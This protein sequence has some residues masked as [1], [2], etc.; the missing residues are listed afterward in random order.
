MTAAGAATGADVPV[1]AAGPGLLPAPPSGAARLQLLGPFRL[2]D[3]TGAGVALASPRAQSLLA[4]LALNRSAPTTRR[5]LSF[6]LWPDSSESGASNNLRQLLHQVRRSWP[7]AGEVLVARNG[8]LTLAGD[9]HLAVDLDAYEVAVG[10]ALEA[11]ETAHPGPA[12]L[13]LEL[14][15]DGY[16]GPLLPAMYDEWILPERERLATR[17]E[18]LL[19]RLIALLEQSGDYRAAIERG[20]ER[21]LLDPLDERVVRVLMR[22]HALNG[23]RA[24]ALR[25]YGACAAALEEAF[26]VEPDETTRAEH[27]RVLALGETATGTATATATHP[28][29]SAA[30]G[31]R[32]PLGG[33]SAAIGS[34]IG[35]DDEWLRVGAAWERMAAGDAHVVVI[36]GVAGIG[37]SR[38]A[39]EL[40]GWATGQGIGAASTRAYQAE[41]RLSFAPIADWLRSPAVAPA[42]ARLDLGTLSEIS[43]L[44]PEL[45]VQR[46]DLPRPSARLESWQRG[47]FFGAL[48]TAFQAADQPL[49]LVLDDL[50]WCDVDTLDWLQFLLRSASASRIL[51]VSTVRSDEIDRGHPMVPFLAALREHDRVTELDLVPLGPDA[52]AALAASV[53]RRTLPPSQARRIF[54][55]TEGNPL[56]IVETVRAELVDVDRAPAGAQHVRSTTGAPLPPRIQATIAA[57]L[58]RL[59]EPARDLASLAATIGRAFTLDVVRAS[60]VDD[61]DRLVGAMDELVRHQLIREGGGGA[62]DFSHDKIREVAYAG[63]TEARRRLLHRRVADALETIHAGNL[64]AVAARIAA[65]CA[66]AGLGDRAATLYQLAAEVAQLVGANGEAIELLRRGLAILD[67]LPRSRDR[68]DRELGLQTALGSSLVA[69][70]GY[71]SDAV[72]TVYARCR[73]LCQVVGRPPAPPVLRALAISA[74]AKVRIDECHA[75]GD[76]LV[77]VAE[78]DDDPIL[79]VEAHYVIAMAQLLAGAVVPA[80]LELETAMASYDPARSSAHIGLY[81]QDPAVVCGI[82]L[83]VALWILGEPEAAE[84]RRAEAVRLAEELGHPFTLSYA[85]VWDAVLQQFRGRADLARMQAEAAIGLGHNQRM[86]FFLALATIIRGWSIAELGDPDGGIAEMR[87]GM[88]SFA[89]T[90]ALAFRTLQLALLAEQL[91]RSGAV[92]RGLTMVAEALAAAERTNERWVEAH[93]HR[94][95]GDMLRAEPAGSGPARAAYGRAIEVARYQGARAFGSRAEAQLATLEAGDQT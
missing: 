56:F 83:S 3:S 74:L 93:L 16:I 77:S 8:L 86:P 9:P 32:P 73:E 28:A 84:R 4:L 51:V 41:G 53:A 52:T 94:L 50:Q 36:G 64:D 48:A 69:T 26:G 71:G 7:G 27:A 20:S 42:L 21:L 18:R 89:A 49:L 47:A 57:R 40:Q 45:L 58:A 70:E 31:R 61:E 85:L 65:H 79:R 95:R 67:G 12:R 1:E 44:L 76:H 33:A 17:H 62:Y 39:A 66:A 5:H 91:G 24:G 82:R 15:V 29:T 37:K 78:R 30:P 92:E 88:R 19:D 34:L 6:L 11:D 72:A 23:D 87:R 59:N 43:R 13:A 75:L 35:R 14:A 68:D 55:E 2:I 10:R 63:T 25:T 38:L 81:A 60:G 54:D 22:L 46:P 80:R 90:G